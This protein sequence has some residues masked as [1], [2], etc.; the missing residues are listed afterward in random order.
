[1]D[2]LLGWLRIAGVRGWQLGGVAIGFLV[3]WTVFQRLRLLFVIIFVA[4]LIAALLTPVSRWLEQRGVPR[5]PSALLTVVGGTLL[6]LA[7]STVAVMQIVNQ[8]PEL[9]GQVDDIRQDVTAW[10][11]QGPLGL[12]Q[13]Q[14]DSAIDRAVG[15]VTGSWTVI[16]SQAFAAVA[17]IGALLT[18]LIL[19][20]FL[21]R[22]ADQ[23]NRWILDRLVAD[24]QR[25]MVMAV[26]RRAGDAL[27]GYIRGVVAIGA[28]EAIAIGGTLLILGVPLASAVAALTFFG[29]FFPVIGATVAGAI[30]VLVALAST[31]VVTGLIVLGIVIL[32]QQLD[33]NLLQ[34]VVMGRAVRLH[35]IV[36]LAAL[37]AGGLL[38]GLV[39]ALMAVPTAAVLTAAGN[40]VRERRHQDAPLA[41]RA[42]GPAPPVPTGPRSGGSEL[43]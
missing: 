11:T 41:E 18:A 19:A 17:A 20:F 6:I 37:T 32:I 38:A 10:L 5:T 3:L 34:P 43:P 36:I 40:E 4:L 15:V 33:G 29:G 12:S 25:E 13:Q 8:A 23:I 28:F 21:V 14:V 22:D 31:G 26:G 42:D 16:V 1:M 2:R 39:G 7:V 9:A 24:D 27:Q 30:A 35:P